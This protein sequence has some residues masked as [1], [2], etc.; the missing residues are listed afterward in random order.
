MRKPTPKRP[1]AGPRRKG[2]TPAFEEIY[3]IVLFDYVGSG[4]SA[5]KAFDAQRY[6]TLHSYAQDLRETK[7][8]RPKLEEMTAVRCE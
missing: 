5:S 4:Q 3:R 1:P 7:S 6:S 2:V 8:S